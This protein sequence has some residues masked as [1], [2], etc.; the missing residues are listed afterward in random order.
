MRELIEVT[1]Y[2][3]LCNVI[4]LDDY[5]GLVKLKFQSDSAIFDC[6]ASRN[7]I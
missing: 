1:K 4:S 7:N 5:G 2:K 3:L 6:R